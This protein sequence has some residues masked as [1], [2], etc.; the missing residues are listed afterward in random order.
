[1]NRAQMQGLHPSLGFPGPAVVETSRVW[2]L[3][4]VSPLCVPSRVTATPQSRPRS[5]R[6]PSALHVSSSLRS[7]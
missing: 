3:R 1:M 6:S 5:A 2:E 4:V 7:P